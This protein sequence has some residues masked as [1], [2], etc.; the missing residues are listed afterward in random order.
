MLLLAVL[1]GGT[2]GD[3]TFIV[4]Q[5]A[6]TPRRRETLK[7]RGIRRAHIKAIGLRRTIEICAATLLRGT[8]AVHIPET[9]AAADAPTGHHVTMGALMAP[10]GRGAL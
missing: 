1:V 9:A 5:S 8:H 4:S 2:Q 6:D 7:L 10:A 3:H